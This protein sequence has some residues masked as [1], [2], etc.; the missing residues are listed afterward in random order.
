MC[1]KYICIARTSILNTSHSL[2]YRKGFEKV[3]CHTHVSWSKALEK[4]CAAL[5]LCFSLRFSAHTTYALD[6]LPIPLLCCTPSEMCSR[7]SFFSF[8]ASFPHIKTCL[9]FSFFIFYLCIPWIFLQ[10]VFIPQIFLH[11]SSSTSKQY[12]PNPLLSL[13]PLGGSSR[14]RAEPPCQLA[15]RGSVK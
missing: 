15:L 12:D 9:G 11:L 2:H 6:F 4:D 7:L 5:S 14:T 10:F 1:L 3:C 8:P 13:P